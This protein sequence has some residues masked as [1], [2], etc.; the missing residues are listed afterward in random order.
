VPGK[1]FNKQRQNCPSGRTASPPLL[2][3]LNFLRNAMYLFASIRKKRAIKIYIQRLGKDLASRYGR[4]AKYSP[5]QVVKT[6]QDRG[7]NW[8]HICYA[9]ALYVSHAQ[10]DKWHEEQGEICD[11]H[12]MREEV[13]V[14]HFGGS[15]DGISSSDFDGGFD[16][17]HGG[18]GFGND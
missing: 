3:A 11:Y 2:W 12:A 1:A 4:A 18:G 10:F 17:G 15:S 7:Y 6:V 16:V 5:G 9:H 8:R 13:A 14:T